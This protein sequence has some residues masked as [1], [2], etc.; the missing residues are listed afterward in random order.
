MESS[1]SLTLLEPH[2]NGASATSTALPGVGGPPAVEPEAPATANAVIVDSRSLVRAGLTALLENLGVNVLGA[3]T[4]MDA[5]ARG[6]RSTRSPEVAF[7][8]LTGEL[9][10]GQLVALARSTLAVPVVLTLFG[11]DVASHDALG[12]DADGYVLIDLVDRD[13]LEW[14]LERIDHGERVVP[15]ELAGCGSRRRPSVLTERCVEVL[16]CL[17][18]GLQDAEV[19]EELGMSISSVRKHI[20][21]AQLRLRARTRTHAVAMAVRAE[22]L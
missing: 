13:L 19:A 15:P 21:T 5:L 11:D 2:A 8:G 14:T 18:R 1:R 12:A 17:A 9:P 20:R 4:L 22:L 7:V 10:A 6:S 16:R 3:H